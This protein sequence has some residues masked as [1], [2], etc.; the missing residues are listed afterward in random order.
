M[1]GIQA[2]LLSDAGDTGE[3]TERVGS[4]RGVWD[5]TNNDDACHERGII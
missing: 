5:D 1:A 4:P 3:R 2:P